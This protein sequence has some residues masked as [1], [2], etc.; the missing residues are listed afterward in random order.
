MVS[1]LCK[2][3]NLGGN[4]HV[5]SSLVPCLDGSSTLPTSQKFSL[6]WKLTEYKM[7]QISSVIGNRK[8][9]KLKFKFTLFIIIFG[10]I[11]YYINFRFLVGF[12]I[13]SKLMICF[14]FFAFKNRHFLIFYIHIETLIFRL[15]WEYYCCLKPIICSMNTVIFRMFSPN[16]FNTISSEMCYITKEFSTFVTTVTIIRQI[17]PFIPYSCIT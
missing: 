12:L 17:S 10:G 4:N 9:G 1:V 16:I 7:L 13:I 8:K 3:E 15:E 2:Q 14:F 6:R 5:E 11:K